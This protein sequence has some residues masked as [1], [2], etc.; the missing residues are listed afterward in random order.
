MKSVAQQ[1]AEQPWDI[2]ADA[3][4]PRLTPISH[5]TL[6]ER[7]YDELRGAIMSGAFAPGETLTIRG[8]AEQLGT[9]V[10][11]AREALRRLATEGAIDVMPNR[12]IRI[13]PM[14]TARI[15]EICRIRL[16][17]EGEA[18]SLAA[19]NAEAHELA[20]IRAF[21][22]DFVEHARDN[23]EHK[24]LLANQRFHFAIYG[25][26]RAP[27]ML[28]IIGMLWIQTGPWLLEPL[29]RSFDRSASRSY[30]EVSIGHHEELIDALAAHDG[31]RAAEAVRAD[32]RDA[33]EQFRT[34]MDS[35][36]AQPTGRGG[37]K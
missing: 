20:L 25:A 37:A 12:S 27:T 16:M 1:P 9:S 30:V 3:D 15:E 28:S 26:A 24:L 23:A 36:T 11:P 21:N 5:R 32:I 29:R 17:L 31:P 34:F 35:A 10:M 6:Y 2:K 7:V 33:A 4:I 22:R 18:A 8:L 13:P 14:K 19:A